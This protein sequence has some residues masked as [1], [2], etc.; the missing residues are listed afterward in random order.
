MMNVTN[1]S[2]V[3]PTKGFTNVSIS[4]SKSYLVAEFSGESNHITNKIPANIT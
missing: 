2:S 3:Q 4:D 1:P